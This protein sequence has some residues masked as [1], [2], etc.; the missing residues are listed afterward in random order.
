MDYYQEVLGYGPAGA[1]L[2]I[3][4]A[5]QKDCEICD[6]VLA[7]QEIREKSPFMVVGAFYHNMCV[8]LAILLKRKKKHL[9][10]SGGSTEYGELHFLGVSA[11]YRGEGIG[12]KLLAYLFEKNPSLKYVTAYVFKKNNQATRLAY[13]RWGFEE[14]PI[15]IVPT[16]P[17]PELYVCYR[18]TRPGILSL[19]ENVRGKECFL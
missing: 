1:R 15:T 16:L 10:G 13:L 6:K 4:N 9:K 17:D 11:K 3:K 2:E 7:D 19:R 14:I 5:L 12:R 8:G 18:L